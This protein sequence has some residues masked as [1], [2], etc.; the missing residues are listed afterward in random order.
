MDT[1]PPP[2]NQ[3]ETKPPQQRLRYEKPHLRV[4]G[5]VRHVTR[6][7]GTASQDSSGFAGSREG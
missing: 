7:V 6:G 3:T 4:V 2:P 1:R 5:E